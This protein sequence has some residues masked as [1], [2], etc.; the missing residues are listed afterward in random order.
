MVTQQHAAWKRRC[1][2]ELFNSQFKKKEAPN[3]T[4]IHIV[5]PGNLVADYLTQYS[6]YSKIFEKQLESDL[7]KTGDNMSSS[8]RVNCFIA[9]STFRS[10]SVQRPRCSA[11]SHYSFQSKPQQACQKAP[12]E[13]INSSLKGK[14][15]LGQI[16]RKRFNE[17]TNQS[18]TSRPTHQTRRLKSIANISKMPDLGSVRTLSTVKTR[19]PASAKS[20]KQKQSDS[21]KIMT[22]AFLKEPDTQ[23]QKFAEVV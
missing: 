22:T 13:P 2:Q 6:D 10:R 9:S 4:R 11:S 7:R 21:R 15:A 23:T 12:L 3:Q 20:S 19:L 5:T 14:D 8:S 18:V 16:V 17:C 1:N